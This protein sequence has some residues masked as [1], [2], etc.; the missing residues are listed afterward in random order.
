MFPLFYIAAIVNANQYVP[1][2]RLKYILG[3]GDDTSDAE[4]HVFHNREVK[5]GLTYFFQ[6]FSVNSTTKVCVFLVLY[7]PY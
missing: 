1:N 7:Y 6:V 4:G 2:Y 5:I 3:A